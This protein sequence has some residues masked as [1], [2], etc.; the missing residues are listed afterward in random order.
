MMITIGGGSSVRYPLVPLAR[1]FFAAGHDVRLV[2]KPRLSDVF[3]GT[4]LPFITLGK[5]PDP[6]LLEELT[7]SDYYATRGRGRL[8]GRHVR[9]RCGP[10]RSTCWSSSAGTR[11]PS[12]TPWPMT[13]WPS[14]WSG[15]RA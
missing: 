4:G 5:S 6:Q 7:R 14:R 11:S 15:A 1:A 3:A 2:G 10:S 8:T 12:P 13:W 9:K